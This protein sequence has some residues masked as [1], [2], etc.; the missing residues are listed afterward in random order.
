MKKSKNR[1][2]QAYIFCLTI[3]VLAGLIPKETRAASVIDSERP[4][5]IS[6]FY[7]VDKRPMPNVEFMLYKV[8]EM[9]EDGEKTI[10]S[11]FADYA[12]SLDNLDSE[13]NKNL[14]ETLAGYIARDHITPIDTGKT[15]RNGI[16]TFPKSAS[17][18]CGV[19]LLL[20]KNHI[21]ANE[22]CNIQPMLFEMPSMIIENELEYDIGIS[23]KYELIGRYTNITAFIIWRDQFPSDRPPQVE[24]Q[25]INSIDNTIHD[26]VVLSPANGWR[27]TWNQL[28]IG[29]WYVVQ[30]E[31]PP[32]YVTS[33]KRDGSVIAII[34]TSTKPYVHMEDGEESSPEDEEP[35]KDKELLTAE[36]ARRMLE[37]SRYTGQTL[38]QT[39]TLWWLVPILAAAGISFL[40]IGFI[41]R[42][43]DE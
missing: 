14:A 13:G 35:V 17:L 38:P 22:V 8:A 33:T 39:G 5:S 41:R 42:K 16:V 30:K 15:G 7:N 40:M 18:F 2:F 1:I 4:I 27:Y 23:P 34:N 24:V 20:S 6:V 43:K 9:S 37:L 11:E 26:T 12:F 19:Y 32:D 31:V 29:S 25:L 36:E 21:L 28:P 3:V 10:T